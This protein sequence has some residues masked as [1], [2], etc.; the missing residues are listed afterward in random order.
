MSATRTIAIAP[1]RKS[2]RVSAG[3]ARAF[4]VFTAGIGRWWPRESTIGK[5]PRKTAVIE[6]RAG[7]HWYEVAEDDTRTNVGRILVWDPPRRFVL[8]W[9]VNSSWKPEPGAGSEVEIRFLADGPDATVVELEHR[10]FEAMGAEAGASLRKD[11]DGGWP[12]MLGRFKEAA[13]A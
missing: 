3:Q 10:N 11:V 12:R 8:S 7:G 6:P 5:T 4:E 1:V 13:E 2:I 9:D